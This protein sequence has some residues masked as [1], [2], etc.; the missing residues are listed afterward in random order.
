VNESQVSVPLPVRLRFGH[1]AVQHLAD[2]IGVDLLHIKGAA[3]DPSLRPPEM[4]GSDVDV[5]VRPEQFPRLDQG[6]REHGWRLFTTFVSGSP[7]G[8]AQTYLHDAWGYIDI[9][10]SFPGIRI[11]PDQAF[12]RL[13]VDRRT[14]EIAGVGCPVPSVTAQAV[15][16]V[17]NAARSQAR[18]RR[19]LAAAWYDA[20]DERRVEMEALVE[21]LDAPVAFGAALGRLD[22][23]RGERD[24]RLWK[25]VSQ[26]GSR[27]EEW[28]ARVRAAPTFAEAV[29]VVA[30]A[31]RVNVDH[32]AYR[33]G[34][35]PTRGEIAIEFF[36]RPAQ[37]IGEAWRALIGRTPR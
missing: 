9:H 33:L 12:E 5:M 3:V 2:A 22:R 27:S 16:L 25:V 35:R 6:M 18:D 11:Q 8:H 28:W 24:Y 10:R 15:L 4:H 14:I 36:H 21:A 37:A 23:Y 1:A 34:R 20:S 30:H 31:P 17:L 13:W 7:F 19:D 32:L 26:G 29:R